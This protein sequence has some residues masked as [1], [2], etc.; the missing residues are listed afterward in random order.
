MC[1]W[2]SWEVRNAKE[3]VWF[4]IGSVITLTEGYNFFALRRFKNCLLGWP[5]SALRNSLSLQIDLRVHYMNWRR[6]SAVAVHFVRN[7][8][9]SRCVAVWA[10]KK[11]YYDF[12]SQ[13]TISTINGG[14]QTAVRTH[15]RKVQIMRCRHFSL[16]SSHTAFNRIIH[17]SNQFE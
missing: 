17:T 11:I 16:N 8:V 10:F 4:G 7:H 14:R 5:L 3:M 15:T 9:F 1:T 2:H 12:D 6:G 13:S